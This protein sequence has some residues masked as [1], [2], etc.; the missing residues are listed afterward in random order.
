MYKYKIDSFG[1]PKKKIKVRNPKIL[2]CKKI[3]FFPN[4]FNRK[5]FYCFDLIKKRTL[6]QWYIDETVENYTLKKILSFRGF[7]FPTKYLYLLLR[8]FEKLFLFKKKTFKKSE[9]LLLGPYMH[10]YAH[11]LHEFIVRLFYIKYSKKLQKKNIFVGCNL[12]KILNSNV[13]SFIFKDLKINY[14]KS[15]KIILFENANYITHIENRFINEIFVK[16][17][18]LLKKE[19]SEFF[20]IRKKNF[21]SYDYV[22]ASRKKA[23]KRHLLNEDSLYTNLK[24]FKFKRVFFEDLSYDDQINLSLNIKILIGYHGTAFSNGGLFMN[25]NAHILEIMHEKYP[26]D[27]AKLF[28]DIQGSNIKRFYCTKN[29]KNLDGECKIDE[30]VNYIKK[31]I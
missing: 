19:C 2:H 6:R 7:Y 16:N 12:K 29:Y 10:A 24:E 31:I 4:L 8:L 30:I 21:R 9:I 27:H 5:I 1:W 11:Q 28:S 14:F 20:K 23:V 22:L 15:N 25:K 18:K 3:F 13:F 26:Q 17:I